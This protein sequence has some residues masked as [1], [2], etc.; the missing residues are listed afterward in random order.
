MKPQIIIVGAS[1]QAAVVADILDAIGEFEVTG[2]LDD[3]DPDRK[4]ETFCGRQILGTTHDLS[5]LRQRG[6]SLAI[7]GF[8]HTKKRLEAAARLTD[9]GFN[10]VSAIHPS[11]TIGT[12]SEI[13]EGSVVKAGAVIDPGVKIGRNVIIGSGAIVTHDSV[14]ADGVRLAAGAIVGASVSLE[15]GAF[16]G[17]G[18]TIRNGATIGSFALVGAGALVI[19]DVAPETVAFGTPARGVRK[20][21]ESDM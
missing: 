21:T 4:G 14:L 16:V 10:L 1:A 12:G 5:R 15:L 17:L 3:V 11:A 13:G 2:F 19:Q 6:I 7:V 18:A 9:A 8:G 20:I